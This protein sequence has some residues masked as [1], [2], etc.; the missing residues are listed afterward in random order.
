[1]LYAQ[2]NTYLLLDLQYTALL[3]HLRKNTAPFCGLA[4]QR[5]QNFAIG[6]PRLLAKDL[7]LE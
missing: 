7:G 4:G 6:L 3:H 5:E 2:E 1:M